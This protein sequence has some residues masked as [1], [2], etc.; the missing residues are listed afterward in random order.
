MERH[1]LRLGA[2]LALSMFVMGAQLLRPPDAGATKCTCAQFNAALAAINAN[3][4]CQTAASHAA[5]VQCAKGAIPAAD[6]ACRGKATK[7]AA[8]S[9]CG[10]S[11]VKC[12]RVTAKG[13]VK[14]SIKSASAKCKAPKGGSASTG[15]G[16]CCRPDAACGGTPGGAFTDCASPSGAFTGVGAGLF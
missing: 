5:Y 3:C 12:C 8:K 4:N 15:T 16:S 7:C 6:K 1:T 11:R 13:K 14:C 10:T 2:V 9:T